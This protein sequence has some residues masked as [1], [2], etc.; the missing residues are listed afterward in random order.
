[1]VYLF[2]WALCVLFSPFYVVF[3]FCGPKIMGQVI[4]FKLNSK[5]KCVTLNV[6]HSSEYVMSSCKKD[7]TFLSLETLLWG[8]RH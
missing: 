3:V 4:F 5:S 6:E 7:V 8:C 1:M 2:L